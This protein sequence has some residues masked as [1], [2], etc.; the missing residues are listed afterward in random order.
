V[1]EI[2]LLKVGPRSAGSHPGPSSYGLGGTEPT[3][4]D[5][6]FSSAISIQDTSREAR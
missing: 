3:V 6:D 5:A 1:D 4:T 2:G